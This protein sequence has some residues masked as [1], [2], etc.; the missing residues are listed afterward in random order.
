MDNLPEDTPGYELVMPF[1]TVASK[2]GPHDDASYCAGWQC[3]GIDALLGMLAQVRGEFTVTAL[4]EV[5]PQ[6]DLI[7]MKHGYQAWR[8]GDVDP[9]DTYVSIRF[10]PA[11]DA[12]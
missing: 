9:S 1:I 4:P 7:A 3:G 8:T 6:F 2:G 10:N 11:P 5:V 12:T